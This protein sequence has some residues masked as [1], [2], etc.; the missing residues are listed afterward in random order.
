[1]S[2]NRLLAA[3]LLLGMARTARAKEE[4]VAYAPPMRT[5]S[6]EVP[7]EWKT[8]EEEEAGGFVTHMLGPLDAA[9][10]YRGGVDVHWVENGRPGFIDI[11]DAT[12]ALRR[13][14]NASGR[15]A[16]ALKR[17]NSG[18]GPARYL[19]IEETL[20]LPT[21]RAPAGRV[22]LRQSVALIAGAQGYFVLRLSSSKEDFLDDRDRF[23]RLL[24]SF[25]ITGN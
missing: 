23:L 18:M 20:R 9:G 16:G 10:L 2:R 3:A 1:M 21:D 7:A 11:K 8:F 12:E 4:F 19:E 24:K 15:H 14:D 13:G 17:V 25:R 22:T 6:C 5:F